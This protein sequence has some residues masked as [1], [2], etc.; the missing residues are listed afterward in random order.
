MDGKTWSVALDRGG[1]L[2]YAGSAGGPFNQILLLDPERGK[3]RS[4][5]E[6]APGISVTTIA[7]VHQREFHVAVA[8]IGNDYHTSLRLYDE[9]LE[10]LRWHRHFDGPVTAMSAD[11]NGHSIAVGAGWGWDSHLLWLDASTGDILADY[12]VPARV[13]SLDLADGRQ[14]AVA[15]Q[16][17][18]VAFMRYFS[19]GSSL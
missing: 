13:N 2:L 15:L 8:L 11:L 12:S 1:E 3:V 10:N 18:S 5:L 9:G 4:S 7:V 16:D 14:L 19:G 17:G 6:L